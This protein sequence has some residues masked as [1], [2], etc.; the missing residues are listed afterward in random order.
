MFLTCI[1]PSPKSPKQDLDVF[2]QR[3]VDKLK[4]LWEYGENTYDVFMNQNF[5]MRSVL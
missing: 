2:L 5:L 1:I 4:I 3:L